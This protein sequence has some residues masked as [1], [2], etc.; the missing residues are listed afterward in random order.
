MRNASLLFKKLFVM[1]R[2]APVLNQSSRDTFDALTLL[3]ALAS[4]AL[5]ICAITP[6]LS[7]TWPLGFDGQIVFIGFLLSVMNICFKGPLPTPLSL[8][9][10]G[11]GTP[12]CKITMRSLGIVLLQETSRI[13][14]H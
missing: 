1:V 7:F 11:M 12:C 2:Y 5:A 3:I 9:K 6:R 8:S 10:P 14:G 4:L 13:Y